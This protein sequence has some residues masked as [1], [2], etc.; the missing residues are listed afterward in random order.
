MPLS[1]L[2]SALSIL[3]PNA[4]EATVSDNFVRLAL[5]PALGFDNTEIV[6]EYNTGNGGIAD[7]AARKNVGDTFFLQ[8]RKNPF[9]LVEVKGK[10][11]HIAQ[12]TPH[13]RTI[14]TQL[15]CQLLGVNCRSAE[16]GIITNA[17]HIQ[18][19]RKHGK[20]IF[21]ATK[22][23][24]LAVENVDE[25]VRKIRDKIE[26]PNRALTVTIYNNKG[27]IGKT[28]TTINLGAILAFLG[29]KV[30]LVDFDFNQLD[31]TNALG[32]TSHNGFIVNLLTQ[33]ATDLAAGIVTYSFR[34]KIKS[35][36]FD[37][38]PADQQMVSCDE[39]KLQQQAPGVH[40]FHE[41]LSPLKNQYDYIFID[42]PP[43]W[44]WMTQL[45]MYAADVVL[46]PT[47]H[48]NFF[49]LRN[50]AVAIKDFLPQ[51]QALKDEG[52]PVALP[53]FFNGE[54]MTDPQKETAIS[55]IERIIKDGQK[56][57]FNLRPYFFPKWTNAK[58]DTYIH[59]IPNYA[60]IANAHFRHVPAVYINSTAFNYYRSFAK[61]YF[62]NDEPQSH[63]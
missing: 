2:Q 35:F 27:G 23:L 38:L 22:C 59:W 41:K 8:E 7:F 17:N 60:I 55:E 29:K 19:F 45:A 39:V 50:A 20:V 16:W 18:L 11:W 63:W 32:L 3:P 33:R 51:V 54:V 47:K 40:T 14:T 34:G 10:N 6:A 12:D 28:T 44:R 56:E 53:I 36:T 21:P 24:E 25:I 4:N 58:K 37:V 30:L 43:N 61:E 1:P 46:L 62:C 31:L 52:T 26:H 48:N 49:S 57:G 9:L 5:L 15:R 13:Y 42:V